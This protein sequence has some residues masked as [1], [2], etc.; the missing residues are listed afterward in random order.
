[1]A[2]AVDRAVMPDNRLR[3]ILRQVPPSSVLWYPGLDYGNWYT[4]TIKDFS[5]NGNNGTIT[6]AWTRLSSGLRILDFIGITDGINCGD[7]AAFQF[8]RTDPFSFLVWASTQ[9]AANY[10]MLAQKAKSTAPYTGYLFRKSNANKLSV[11]LYDDGS[12][13]IGQL[14]TANLLNDGAFHSWGFTYDGSE[15]S[16]GLV[17]YEDGA[18]KASAADEDGVFDTTMKYAASLWLGLDSIGAQSWN[19]G[20]ALPLMSNRVL[21]AAEIKDI[22][23]LTKPLLGNYVTTSLFY[24]VVT[25]VLDMIGLPGSGATLDDRSAA[26]NDGT[27]TGATWEQLTSGHSVLVL[28]GTD[29]YVSMGD[30]ATLDFAS[31]DALTFRFWVKPTNFTNP[32]DQMIYD[33]FS[34]AASTGFTIAASGS[35]GKL[36]LAIGGGAGYPTNWIVVRTAAALS[37]GVWQHCVIT[38]DGSRTAAGV[39]FYINGSPVASEIVANNTPPVDQTNDIPAQLGARNLGNYEFVGSLGMAQ[40][41]SGTPWTAAQVL[42]NY[43][44]ERHLYG[45]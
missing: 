16:A 5:G 33:K 14:S 35:T 28:D 4:G 3:N 43:Q 44:F 8:E 15:T 39:K 37:N 32:A 18:V 6:G 24:P 13:R 45:V 36:A 34:E 1:M 38:Y 10:M 11:Q 40:I 31:T 42:A 25:S 41:V 29:D 23:N 21:S 30:S 19:G 7:K 27:I 9:D 20:Y 26:N 12:H 22:Y 2:L 17:L